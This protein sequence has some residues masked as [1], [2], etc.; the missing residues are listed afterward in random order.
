MKIKTKE[1][2]PEFKPVTFEIT[3]ESEEEI[4]TLWHRFNVHVYNIEK[5]TCGPHIFDANLDDKLSREVWKL[6]DKK[7]EEYIQ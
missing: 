3:C 2:T 7:L 4:I 6:I 5:G 1:A